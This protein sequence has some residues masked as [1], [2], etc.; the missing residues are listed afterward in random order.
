MPSPEELERMAREFSKSQ[1]PGVLAKL[2]DSGEIP[3]VT[4]PRMN[5][6]PEIIKL[7]RTQE[8]PRVSIREV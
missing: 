3:V 4:M 5:F 1:P 2:I 8:I 7:V 6:S